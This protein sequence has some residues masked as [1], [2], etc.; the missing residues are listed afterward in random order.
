M[1]KIKFY[2][3]SSISSTPEL[4]MV[5]DVSGNVGIG[6]SNPTKALEVVGILVS[7]ATYI[8]MALHFK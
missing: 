5:I 2:T 4:K 7:T 1:E 8:K 3:K 6:E